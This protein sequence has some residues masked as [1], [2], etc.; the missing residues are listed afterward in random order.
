MVNSNMDHTGAHRR[1]R[2]I[3]P[4]FLT[5]LY[6]VSKTLDDCTSLEVLTESTPDINPLLHFSWWFFVYYNYTDSCI[7]SKSIKFEVDLLVFRRMLAMLRPLMILT[8]DTFKIISH[9]NFRC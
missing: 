4:I 2:L 8:E 7:E 6:T 3:F 1:A 9:S 5:Y